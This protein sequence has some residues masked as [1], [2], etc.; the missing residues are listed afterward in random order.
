MAETG[1]ENGPEKVSLETSY[2][3]TILANATGP[4]MQTHDRVS[5]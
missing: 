2:N 3:D 4:Q 5:A 1:Q